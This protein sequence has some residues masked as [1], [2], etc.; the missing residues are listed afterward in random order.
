[1]N[2]SAWAH[3]GDDDSKPVVSQRGRGIKE[4][5]SPGVEGLWSPPTTHAVPT[6]ICVL[7]AMSE[8]D[9]DGSEGKHDLS[10][11]HQ[12][13]RGATIGRVLERITVTTADRSTAHAS[14]GVSRRQCMSRFH[15]LPW[16]VK[17]TKARAGLTLGRIHGHRCGANSG[18]TKLVLEK[19]ASSAWRSTGTH[20]KYRSCSIRFG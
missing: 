8:M 4:I 10:R 3:R 2:R 13:A 15:A 11:L 9:G 1:M 7:A 17:W 12:P 20:R 18:Q 19:E 16:S 14:V 5:V 6:A